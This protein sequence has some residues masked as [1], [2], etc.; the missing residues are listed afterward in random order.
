MEIRWF[1]LLLG[2]I[3]EREFWKRSERYKDKGNFGLRY[4]I[5]STQ[6]TSWKGDILFLEG[7]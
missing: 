3:A 5:L 4:F 6:T 1:F 7:R 2:W